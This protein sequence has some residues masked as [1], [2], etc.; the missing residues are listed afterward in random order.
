MSGRGALRTQLSLDKR[1][2]GSSVALMI[3]S[4]LHPRSFAAPPEPALHS[5]ELPGIVQAL[6]KS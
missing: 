2:A 3:G 1:T 4:N 5:C 6:Q